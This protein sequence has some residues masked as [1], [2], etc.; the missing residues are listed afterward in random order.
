MG[1]E[2]LNL[3]TLRMYYGDFNYMIIKNNYSY[4][5]SQKQPLSLFFLWKS[6][7]DVA[8]PLVPREKVH[9]WTYKLHFF[10][11]LIH[12]AI[13]S[14]GYEPGL[15]SVISESCQLCYPTL[16][17]TSLHLHRP[18]AIQHLSTWQC[19]K[20]VV[21]GRQTSHAGSALPFAHLPLLFHQENK[22]AFLSC[23]QAMT[24]VCLCLSQQ[25]ISLKNQFP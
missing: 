21:P 18:G 8:S 13:P 25:D 9:V 5:I 20:I 6:Y 7:C 23:P 3:F 11:T 4:C 16:W 24:S 19:T 22:I 10:T 1:K 2:G 14:P 15:F 17:I 12:V